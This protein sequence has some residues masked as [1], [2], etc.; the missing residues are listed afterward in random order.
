MPP[1]G[2]TP[3]GHGRIGQQIR[4]KLDVKRQTGE[5]SVGFFSD[6]EDAQSG[7]VIL[8]TVAKDVVRKTTASTIVGPLGGGDKTL[9]LVSISPLHFPIAISHNKEIKSIVAYPVALGEHRLW[10]VL[11]SY[12]SPTVIKINDLFLPVSKHKQTILRDLQIG[13]FA[14]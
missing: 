7:I 6:R 12:R 11:P 10:Q 14:D 5:G 2:L 4:Q 8:T 1:V 9:R 3:L 13:F